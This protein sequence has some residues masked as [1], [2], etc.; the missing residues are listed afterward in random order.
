M[1]RRAMTTSVTTTQ[2]KAAQSAP[3]PLEEHPFGK[4]PKDLPTWEPGPPTRSR[5]PGAV[6]LEVVDLAKKSD[7]ARFVDMIH[8][9]YAGD[10]HFIA[11]LRM[12]QMHF[13][14][15]GKNA[16]LSQLDIHAV[17]A[18]R[19]GRCVGRITGHIDHTTCSD[20][21]REAFKRSSAGTLYYPTLPTTVYKAFLRMRVFQGAGVPTPPTFRIN[22]EQEKILKRA[23]FYSHSSQKNF[24]SVKYAGGAMMWLDHEYFI[25]TKKGQ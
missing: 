12:Q 2:S 16:S 19:E 22:I 11:P 20:R 21:A 6:R 15:T 4:P 9:L 17:L 5:D 23:A 8:P 24:S 18:Y 7:R 14:D 3:E 10:P 1:L 25:R 13:L